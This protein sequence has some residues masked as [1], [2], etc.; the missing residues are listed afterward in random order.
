M[1]ACRICLETANTAEASRVRAR[2]REIIESLA[3]SAGCKADELRDVLLEELAEGVAEI[4][5]VVLEERRPA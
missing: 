5:G 2:S 3:A 4:A 1:H